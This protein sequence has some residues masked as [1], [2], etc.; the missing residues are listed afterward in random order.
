MYQRYAIYWAPPAG[1]AMDRF[2]AAWFGRDAETGAPVEPDRHGLD[3]D[4]WERA[5]ASPRRYAL[6]G[7]MKAP[8]RPADAVSEADLSAAL[9][10][11]C[12]HRRAF[13]TGPLHLV[14]FDRYLALGPT[15]PLSDLEWLAAQC[16]TAFDHFRAPLTDADRARRPRDLPPNEAAL[17]EQFGYPYIFHHFEFHI[18]LAGPLDDADLARVREALRPAIAAFTVEPFRM[19]RLCLFGDP[20]D[21][22]PFRLINRHALMKA[23]AR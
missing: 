19:D 23:G 10:A 7:T 12:L 4:L 5:V 11:F 15:V 18:T 3:P 2:G 6:H 17:L 22:L 9:A 13:F 1:S 16:V 21:G 8:F 20:G 14:T